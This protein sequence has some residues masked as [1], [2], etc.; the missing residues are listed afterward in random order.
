VS[1]RCVSP[2]LHWLWLPSALLL[3]CSQPARAE[4]LQAPI[5]GKRIVL[6]GRV[7][8]GASAGGFSVEAGGRALRPPADRAAIG[9]EVELSTAATP[10]DCAEHAVPLTVI[11]T[12]HW[13]VFELA[14]VVL[15]PDDGRVDARGR[16]LEGVSIVW[17]SGDEQGSDTCRDPAPDGNFEACV[18]GLGSD[19]VIGADAQLSWLPRGGRAADDAVFFDAG[20]RRIPA[21]AFTLVPARVILRRLVPSGAAVDLSAG[22]GEVPLVHPEAVASAECKALS[23]EMTE[24]E[25]LVRGATNLVNQL[26][27]KIRLRPR[28]VLVVR[29]IFDSQPSVKLPVLHCPMSIVSGPPVRNSENARVVVQLQGGCARDLSAV[30]FTTDRG[31]VPVVQSV[32]T[33]NGAYVLLGLGYIGDDDVTLTALRGPDGITLA[34]TRMPTRPAPRVRASLEVPGFPNLDFIPN[35]RSAVVHVSTAGEH[36]EYALLPIEGVY[37]VESRGSA[38]LIHGDPNAA[39]LTALRFALRNSALPPPLDHANLAQN[40]DPLQR[41]IREANIPAPIGASAAGPDP[42]VELICGAGKDEQRIALGITDHLPFEQRDTCR[43]VFHR[44]RLLPEY[45]TQKLKFEIDVTSLDGASRGSAHVSEVITLRAGPEPRYAWVHGVAGPFDRVV[46]RIYHEADESHYMGASEIK[47]GVPAVQ[48]SLVLGTGHLRLYATT[49]IP[50]GLYRFSDREHSGVL[51]LNFGV[52]SRLTW[53]ESDGAE[54]FLGLEG[55]IMVIGLANSESESGESL[56]QVGAVFGIGLAVP[57]ANRAT[58]TQASINLHAW[59]EADITHGDESAGRFAI[60]FGPSITIG[61]VGVNL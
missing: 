5:G 3:L 44:E 60:I 54:G 14:S 31:P 49:A 42:L 34:A 32:N 27:V 17:K 52:I 59:V 55:G 2:R 50:T 25:L 46:V 7:V 37:S 1:L 10:A 6:E 23:C 43:V 15:S 19:A 47:T 56:T 11:A 13:P 33:P 18:W 30:R 22:H 38:V 21:E 51:S 39:G 8:C 45:G 24:G 40:E 12:D 41:P 61:N 35:N 28:V 16:A 20:G 57:I 48:W 58:L 9:R 36:E 29:E 26:E 4:V 53:L